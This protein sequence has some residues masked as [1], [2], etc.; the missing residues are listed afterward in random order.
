MPDLATRADRERALMAA[1]LA[2]FREYSALTPSMIPTGN[3]LA[4]LR[5]AVASE[6]AT[7]FAE[8]AARFAASRD[9]DI[10]ED[11]I[12]AASL[13]WAGQFSDALAGEVADNSWRFLQRDEEAAVVFGTE[14]A[15]KIAITE[16]TRAIGAGENWAAAFAGV[17][18]LSGESS[19]SPTRLWHTA[20]DER[21][22]D[23]CSP[24]DGQSESVWV[25]RFPL[26]PPAHPHCRCWLDWE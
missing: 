15:G 14:R 8:A 17:Y 23:E 1:L 6:L 10:P 26:G 24:L 9:W 2:V 18:L 4:D 16:T 22:C 25:S 3:L 11:R 12:R 5:N 13:Y 20:E 7:S 21:V 19:A